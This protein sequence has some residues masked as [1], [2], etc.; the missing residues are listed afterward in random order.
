MPVN[1]PIR[2]WC[3]PGELLHPMDGDRSSYYV[4]SNSSMGYPSA[5]KVKKILVPY[6]E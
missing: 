1:V 6:L 5:Y 2:I 3:F 4:Y